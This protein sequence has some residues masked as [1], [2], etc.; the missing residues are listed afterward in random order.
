MQWT[1]AISERASL[2]SAVDECI[3]PIA[4]VLEGER[5]DLAIAFVSA[6]HQADYARLPALLEPLRAR[7]TLACSAGGVIGAGREIEGSP[8]VAVVA[9]VLPGVRL[10]EF[11]ADTEELPD[12]LAGPQEWAELLGVDTPGEGLLLLADPFSFDIE[13]FLLGVDASF[14]QLP[15]IGGLASGGREAGSNLLVLQDEARHSGV[16]GVSFHGN[17]QLDTVVAQ[18]CRPVGTPMFIT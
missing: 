18:G 1:S 7:C 5:P 16:V 15:L 17:I 8:A 13:S 3:A 9:A 6:D 4:S 12:P 10:E 2:E 11:A 14:P